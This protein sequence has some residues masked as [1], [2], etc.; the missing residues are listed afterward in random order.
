[1]QDRR[2]SPGADS[3]NA[4][5]LLRNMPETAGFVHLTFFREDGDATVRSRGVLDSIGPS[6]HL[7]PLLGVAWESVTGERPK[8]PREP[9]SP[10]GSA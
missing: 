8:R 5:L 1:M 7:L 4:V 9:T 3:V 10:S 2:P 6:V